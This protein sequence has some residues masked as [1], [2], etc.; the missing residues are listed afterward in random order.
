LTHI[1]S[2]GATA[3]EKLLTDEGRIV[4]MKQAFSYQ[5][6]LLF[7]VCSAADGLKLHLEHAGD[8]VFQTCFTMG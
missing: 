4:E 1:L 8:C 7:D 3:Q 5:Y 2:R 6:T